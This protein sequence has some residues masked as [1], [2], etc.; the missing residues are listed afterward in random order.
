MMFIIISAWN[1]CSVYEYG[2]GGP[3]TC[4]IRKVSCS[5]KIYSN[6]HFHFFLTLRCQRCWFALRPCYIP[7]NISWICAHCKQEYIR[8]SPNRNIARIR[9]LWRDSESWWYRSVS[10]FFVRSSISAYATRMEMKICSLLGKWHLLVY[11]IGSIDM[12]SS[13]NDLASSMGYPSHEHESIPEVQEAIKRILAASHNAGKYA[14]MF[15]TAAEH[16]RARF[17]QGC[18]LS[19]FSSLWF[20]TFFLWGHLLQTCFLNSLWSFQ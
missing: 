16:V 8:C 9:K 15:C 4:F 19:F 7:T 20:H 13:P 6:F 2:G 10:L 18:E 12:C 1:S 3:K 5:D 17:A 14:G 11:T